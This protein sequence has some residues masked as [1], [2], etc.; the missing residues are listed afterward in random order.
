MGKHLEG[1]VAIVTGS[2]QGV[3]R[4]I[5]KALAAEGCKVVTN[6]RKPVKPGEMAQIP[7]EKV[8]KLS[9]ELQEWIRKEYEAFSGDA[10]TTAAAIRE[11]GGEATACF[12]DIADFDAAK[13]IVDC[14]VENYGTVDIVI[15]V[16]GAFGFCAI[17]EMDKALWDKVTGVKPA[18][19]WNVI[20]HAV[21]YMIEK[22]WGRI[23]NCASPAFTGGDLRQS[24]YCA[25]NA[26]VIGLTR[27]LAFELKEHNITVNSFCP[28]ARTRASVDME[29]FDKTVE[30]G[31]TSTITGSPIMTFDE[32]PLPDDFAP[33]FAYLCTDEA[34]DITGDN[35]FCM[36]SFIG[37]Y[38]LPEFET[39]IAREPGTG[40][41]TV[42][43]LIKQAP[44]TLFKDYRS[45]T[46]PKK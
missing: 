33:F 34:K 30:E 14:A 15:N 2:G 11:A 24:E 18:G 19:H 5:A 37:K 36:G 6:N 1:K 9:A 29:V 13:K 31:K 16:A 42:D 40:S 43:D 28:A 23:I 4:V 38:N 10:E 7:E 22:G 3:G 46:D 45:I 20:R 12:G 41:W 21:P 27:G 35:F 17:E 39:T 32:T 8:K 44:E 25:A 26:G